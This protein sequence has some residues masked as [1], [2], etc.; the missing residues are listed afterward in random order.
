MLE[1]PAQ[2]SI[3]FILDQ[4][5]P[6]ARIPATLLTPDGTIMATFFVVENGVGTTGD[7]PPGRYLCTVMDSLLGV[8]PASVE[9]VS[10]RT[11]D[12]TLESAET[13]KVSVAFRHAELC[14]GV[15]VRRLWKHAESE[16][17]TGMPVVVAGLTD[18][19]CV[20]TMRLP[21]GPHQFTARTGEGAR[22]E[23][24]FVVRDTD[25]PQLFE[26]DLE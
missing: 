18:G 20:T 17:W 25:E 4:P 5:S 23:L 2:A 3:D 7:V 12:V 11:T 10:S 13:R 16:V 8:T 26:I 15:M 1:R 24:L 21:P 19:R 14:K 22:G 9:V 6:P